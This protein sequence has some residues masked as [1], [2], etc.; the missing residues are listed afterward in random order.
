MRHNIYGKHLGRNKNQ[1]EAL[2]RGL[3][4]SLILNSFI[5]TTEAKVKFIKGRVDK[6]FIKAKKGDNASLKVLT[7]TIPQKEVVDKLLELAKKAKDRNSGFTET[8]RLGKR[9]GDGAMM[10]KISLAE[11]EK[12]KVI[13]D[14]KD[15]KESDS[16]EEE[17]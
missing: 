7:E 10:M 9:Q 12:Q 1:R 4:R 13:S 11:S 3:I 5:I 17:K 16:K 14:K 15:E 8:V 2:F 6:L